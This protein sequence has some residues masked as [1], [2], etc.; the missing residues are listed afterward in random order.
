MLS[1][2]EALHDFLQAGFQHLPR[3]PS[4]PRRTER[5][6]G[7]GVWVTD[8]KRS[9]LPAAGSGHVRRVHSP[10]F[11]VGRQVC[12]ALWSQALLYR[13]RSGDQPQFAPVP[14]RCPPL[15]SLPL[16]PMKPSM[17]SCKQGSSICPEHPVLQGERE[18]G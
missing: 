12:F 11:S 17:T 6:V 8:G 1:A 15:P 14:Q 13:D 2:T 18:V 9:E 4:A 5:K 16:V 10:M 7:S 3:A